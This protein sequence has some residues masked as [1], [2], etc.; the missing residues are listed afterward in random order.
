MP[1]TV[2]EAMAIGRPILTTDAPGCRETVLVGE[3]GYLVP[4]INAEALAE[5][6]IWFIENPEQWEKMGKRSRELAEEKYDVHKIN[7][8]LIEIMELEQ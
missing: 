7:A 8:Q 1:R 4:K 3:N 6:I 5:R 2:L